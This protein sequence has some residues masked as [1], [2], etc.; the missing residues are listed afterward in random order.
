[1]VTRPGKRF[2]TMPFV[3]STKVLLY[4][5][6]HSPKDIPSI[7]SFVHLYHGGCDSKFVEDATW[8]FLKGKIRGLIAGEVFL[9]LLSFKLHRPRDASISKAVFLLSR[10][11]KG[12]RTE[13][14]IRVPSDRDRIHNCWIEFRPAAHLWAAFTLLECS[15]RSM[16][17]PNASA[18]EIRSLNDDLILIADAL[19]SEA[20]AAGLNFDPDPWTVPDGFPGKPAN[21]RD[22]IQPPSSWSIETLMNYRAPVRSKFDPDEEAEE[23]RGG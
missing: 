22:L 13:S 16:E 4:A 9:C 10:E 15:G 14:G 21:V 23:H 8:R 20:T 7:V 6:M 12:K 11:L 1:M 18:K 2:A 3:L 5:I 19:L 17:P